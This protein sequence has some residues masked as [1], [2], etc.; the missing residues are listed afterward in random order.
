MV[1]CLVKHRD[2]ALDV[3]VTDVNEGLRDE[4]SANSMRVLRTNVTA[5]VAVGTSEVKHEVARR[6]QK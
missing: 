5:V 6:Q 4:E 3:L 1:K 2:L